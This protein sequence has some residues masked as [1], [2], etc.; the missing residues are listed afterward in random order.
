VDKNIVFAIEHIK[1][2]TQR[3]YPH[4]YTLMQR[5]GELITR[6]TWSAKELYA[7]KRAHAYF[8]ALFPLQHLKR[9]VEVDGGNPRYH[10]ELALL[11]ESSGEWKKALEALS[12]AK[13]LDPKC[14][15]YK[16]A[17]V[18]LYLK[19]KE[20]SPAEKILED[21]AETED[22]SALWELRGKMALAVKEWHAAQR[23]FTRLHRAIPQAPHPLILRAHSYLWQNKLTQAGED[24]GKAWN[25]ILQEE[26]NIAN[27]YHTSGG[28]K[29]FALFYIEKARGD[30][31]FCMARLSLL[32]GI[33]KEAI[34]HCQKG[35]KAFEWGLVNYPETPFSRHNLEQYPE[36]AKIHSDPFIQALPWSV[37]GLTDYQKQK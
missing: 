5:A 20:I 37:I 27:L 29:D 21:M 22:T 30:Y 2:S 17:Q 4:I 14:A 33:H 28:W 34:D 24:L 7:L 13:S 19:M 9:A 10:F 36:F 1:K 11:L 32:K 6:K 23:A 26:K 12:K 18:R 25:L 16:F 31:H 15:L 3:E 8:I 35:V